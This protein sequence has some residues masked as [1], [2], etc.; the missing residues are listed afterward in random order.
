MNKT[1]ILVVGPKKQQQEITSYLLSHNLKASEQVRNLGIIL[2]TDLNF[3]NHISNITRSSFY[4]LRNTA[5][6]KR[7]ISQTNPDKL[8][9][10]FILNR[11]YYYS[12]LFTGLSKH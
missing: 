2:D 11:A 3:K 12:A 4:H 1:E 6:E 10:A 9:H 7:L 8:V 5:K